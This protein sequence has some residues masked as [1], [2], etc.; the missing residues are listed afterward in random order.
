[1]EATW[2]RALGD[3]GQAL[4]LQRHRA[5]EAKCPVVGGEDVV[6]GLCCYQ[7]VVGRLPSGRVS[8]EH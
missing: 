5:I 1:M 6:V 8:A 7:P 4:D 2:F 3:A